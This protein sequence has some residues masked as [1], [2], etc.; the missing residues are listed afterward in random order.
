MVKLSS[1]A[2]ADLT[3]NV[4][5]RSN[6]FGDN[7]DDDVPQGANDGSVHVRTLCQKPYT[8]PFIPGCSI[9]SYKVI[10]V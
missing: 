2:S 8:L 1:T 9:S 10:L 3:G 4:N 7:D 6:D 5:E